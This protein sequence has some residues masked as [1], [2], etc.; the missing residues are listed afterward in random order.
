[1]AGLSVFPAGLV[2]EP[3]DVA[4]AVSLYDEHLTG[5]AP[6]SAA[7]IALVGWPTGRHH[8][9]VKAAEARL[10]GE[11]GASEVWLAL[12]REPAPP[13]LDSA[14]TAED[15]VA[16]RDS[17]VLADMIAVAQAVPEGVRFG[18]LATNSREAAL[19]DKAGAAIVAV[20]AAGG[21]VPAVSAE[22]A[23]FGE[24]ASID[25]TIEWLSRGAGR[26]FATSPE[27]AVR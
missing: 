17:A 11:M 21:V 23:V 3:L 24:V 4:S 14:G 8:S 10:A 26:V 16:G 22:V 27:R 9:L 2:V 5:V 15:T 13:L 7:V 19:A 6:N 25:D 12:P 1:M 20:D 18:V